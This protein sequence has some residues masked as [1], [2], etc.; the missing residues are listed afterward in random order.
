MAYLKYYADEKILYPEEYS[1]LLDTNIT[2]YFYERLKTRYKFSQELRFS[3]RGN[4]RCSLWR[5]KL[6]YSC[7]IGALAHEVAHAI[8]YRKRTAGQRFHTKKH[9]SIMK[10]VIQVINN[11]K[12]QWKTALNSKQDKRIETQHKQLIRKKELEMLKK[13]PQ[14]K[15]EQLNRRK[16][17]LERKLKALTTRIKSIDRKKNRLEKST[18]GVTLEN[19]SSLSNGCLN[20]SV[21]N[22]FFFIYFS[23]QN[24]IENYI[25]NLI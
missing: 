15:I 14:Y 19:K 7:P 9:K 3:N 23:L 1:E 4:P 6:P 5:I 2:K 22:L 17:N 8:Q 10:R 16:K 13:T 25:N 20:R 18:G 24:Q 21:S 11:N 12:E